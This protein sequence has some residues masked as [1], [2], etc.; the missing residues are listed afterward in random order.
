MSYFSIYKYIFFNQPSNITLYSITK[1]TAK[2]LHLIRRFN[3]AVKIQNV[4]YKFL[5]T[6]NFVSNLLTLVYKLIENKL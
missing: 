3:F 2:Y 5:G 1:L 6:D 4:S